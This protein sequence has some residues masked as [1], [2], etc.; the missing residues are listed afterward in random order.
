MGQFRVV[1]DAVGGHGCMREVSDGEVV[2][3]CERVGCP[4]CITREFVRR[5]KRCGATVSVARIEHW[6]REQAAPEPTGQVVDDLLT[7]IRTGSF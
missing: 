1:V 3:G 7:G 2:I 4:D 5:L 6:P